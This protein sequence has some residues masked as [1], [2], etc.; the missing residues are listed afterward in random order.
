M[1]SRPQLLL[2]PDCTLPGCRHPVLTDGD[3][4]TSCLAVW[5]TY[6]HRADTDPGD[7]P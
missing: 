5:G 2:L 3:A 7:T 6:L 4:C 1:T